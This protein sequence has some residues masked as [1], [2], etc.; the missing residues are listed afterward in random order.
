MKNLTRKIF[1]IFTGLFAIGILWVAYESKN[2]YQSFPSW[3]FFAVITLLSSW[4]VTGVG[5][6]LNKKWAYYAAPLIL[7]LHQCAMAVVGVW[8]LDHIFMVAIPVLLLVWFSGKLHLTK[9]STGLR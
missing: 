8:R 4:S 7:I 5:L 3:Y 2:A 9:Q 1:S 6:F